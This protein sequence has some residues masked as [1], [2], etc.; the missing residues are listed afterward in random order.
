MGGGAPVP[1]AS[2]RLADRFT[3]FAAVI[4]RLYTGLS[5]GRLLAAVLAPVLLAGCFGAEQDLIGSH[6]VVPV[7]LDSLVTFNGTPY[8]LDRRK[9]GTFACELRLKTDTARQCWD[10][11]RVKFERTARGNL[12]VQ[13]TSVDTR[14]IDSDKSVFLLVKRPDSSEYQC[15]YVLGATA[16][17]TP[18]AVQQAQDAIDDRFGA[19]SDVDRKTLLE[20][21]DAYETSVLPLDPECP[22]SRLVVVEHDA[23]RF[24]DE[25]APPRPPRP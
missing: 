5:T 2:L 8:R 21:V 7:K 22:A 17:G 1:S 3:R 24:S 4:R 13:A 23:L 9:Q 19:G 6:A 18:E 15:W 10:R 25:P 11:Y 20:I 16:D 12:I 14:F